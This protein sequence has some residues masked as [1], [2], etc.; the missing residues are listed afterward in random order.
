MI[1]FKNADLYIVLWIKSRFKLYIVS[2]T[3]CMP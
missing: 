1:E 2:N 3:P